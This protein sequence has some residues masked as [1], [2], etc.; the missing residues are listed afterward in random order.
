MKKSPLQLK[1]IFYPTVSYKAIADSTVEYDGKPIPA[2]MD[3]SVIYHDDGEHFAFMCL[4]QENKEREYVY[5]FRV[6]AFTAFNIDKELIDETYPPGLAPPLLAANVARILYTSSRE[7]LATATCR[8]PYG[9]VG[10]EAMVIEPEDVEVQ[11]AGE[12]S[13]KDIIH[14]I[15]GESQTEAAEG[16]HKNSDESAETSPKVKAE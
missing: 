5:E 1:T 4:K 2:D 13:A 7:M 8:A 16:F 6:D 11:L 10:I 9:C 15:F 3:V 12:G 14:A